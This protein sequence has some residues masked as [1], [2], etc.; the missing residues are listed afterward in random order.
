MTHALR[1]LSVPLLLLLLAGCATTPAR[2]IQRN[3]ELFDSLP[4]AEQARIRG[5]QIALGYTADMVRIA[6]GDPQR[7]LTRRTPDSESAIWLY[8]DKLRRYERQRADID[9]LLI[10]GP[11]G[12]RSIGGSAWVNVLQERE[13]MRIRVEFQQGL[14]TAIEQPATDAPGP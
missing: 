12:M 14:V 1:L 3:Q 13:I 11:G 8:L 7:Q 10:S 6:L 4:V 5:G 2:R 9:G